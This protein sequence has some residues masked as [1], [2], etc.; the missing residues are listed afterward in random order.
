MTIEKFITQSKYYVHDPIFIGHGKKRW[1]YTF[2]MK[3]D[4]PF[5]P[6]TKP[7][8]FKKIPII[9]ET[10]EEKY[11]REFVNGTINP[12][13]SLMKFLKKDDKKKTSKFRSIYSRYLP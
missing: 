11:Q 2:I 12:T 6:Y 9:A 3:L 13:N 5:S 7:K 1:F 4:L 8:D 10:K